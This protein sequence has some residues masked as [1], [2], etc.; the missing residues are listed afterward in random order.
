MQL[1]QSWQSC[2]GKYPW[3]WQQQSDG[4]LGLKEFA[5][6]ELKIIKSAFYTDMDKAGIY[7]DGFKEPFWN[8]WVF[9]ACFELRDCF[10]LNPRRIDIV[11]NKA[12]TP[13]RSQLVPSLWE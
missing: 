12:P 9:S 2:F 4:F 5:C 10:H 6:P 1:K 8:F 13:I 7:D 11:L 3:D